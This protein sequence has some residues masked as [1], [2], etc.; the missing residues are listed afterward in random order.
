MDTLAAAVKSDPDAK[1]DITM[2]GET[3]TYSAKDALSVLVGAKVSIIDPKNGDES[4]FQRARADPDVMSSGQGDIG[5]FS[6]ATTSTLG[7]LTADSAARYGIKN[8]DNLFGDNLRTTFVHKAFHLIGDGNLGR[9]AGFPNN[10]SSPY[11][12][13]AKRLR[14]IR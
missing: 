14:D 10:H 11:D 1:V 9:V 3:N 2:G 8:F 12:D 7:G 6:R 13:T 5:I 4:N